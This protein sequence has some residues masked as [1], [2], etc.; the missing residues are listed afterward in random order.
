MAHLDSFSRDVRNGAS[1]RQGTVVGF[2]GSSGN[3]EGGSPHVHFQVH[4]RG[5]APTNPK[6]ILD[7]WINEAIG[8]V[9]E[10]LASYEIGLP[11]P[12]T[13]A[14]MLR[15]L[16]SGSLGG[17]NTFDAPQLWRAGG[18]AVVVGSGQGQ[19]L[20]WLR[21]QQMARDVLAPLTPDVLDDVAPTSAG[22]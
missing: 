19:T 11:R 12:L 20:S 10:I 13:A 17:P 7:R 4:P 21:A 6:T 8:R 18:G 16:D 1:V 15:R 9:Q 5:G 2:V 22:G 14:G 3:A